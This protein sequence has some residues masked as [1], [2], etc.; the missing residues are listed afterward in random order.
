ML[1][2]SIQPLAAPHQSIH[3]WT[4]L[5]LKNRPPKIKGDVSAPLLAL[6]DTQTP[7]APAKFALGEITPDRAKAAAEMLGAA[8]ASGD[9]RGMR[10][11]RGRGEG[12]CIH[13]IPLH[14]PHGHRN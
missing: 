3:G 12:V 13:S 7:P 6:P 5:Y 2:S 11:S 4:F 14:P 8:G 10:D 9:L 1:L